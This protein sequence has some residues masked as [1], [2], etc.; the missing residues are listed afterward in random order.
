MLLVVVG[1]GHQNQQQDGNQGENHNTQNWQRQQGDVELLIQVFL[2]VLHKAVDVPSLL[3]L[4]LQTVGVDHIADAHNGGSKPHH[5]AEQR[6]QQNHE[7]V[8]V[9]VPLR[10]HGLDVEYLLRLDGTQGAELRDIVHGEIQRK[11]DQCDFQQRHQNGLDILLP[12]QVS[13]PPENYRQLDKEVTLG[14]S[15]A[16][17]REKPGNCREETGYG[18]AHSAQG[19]LTCFH[20]RFPFFVYSAPYA[21]AY[22]ADS[23]MNCSGICSYSTGAQAPS[24]MVSRAFWMAASS[25]LFSSPFAIIWPRVAVGSQYLPATF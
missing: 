3:R 8:V 24:T 16:E 13:R 14:Q 25:A 5:K 15:R 22:G 9:V 6:E 17:F 20:R 12:A 23:Q 18:A 21:L 19:I 11:H 10:L 2:D 7:G 1:E 4:E